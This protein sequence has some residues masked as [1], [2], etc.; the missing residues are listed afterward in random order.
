MPKS[1]LTIFKRT[2]QFQKRE[3]FSQIPSDI[4]GIYILHLG[5]PDDVCRSVYVG[6]SHGK[7]GIKQRISEHTRHTSDHWKWTHFSVYEVHDNVSDVQIGELE[8]LLLYAHRKHPGICTIN[9]QKRPKAFRLS[10]PN[11]VKEKSFAKWN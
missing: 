8:G 11:G 6:R 10:P 9:K 2:I 4:R 3:T 1:K 7:V 5:N